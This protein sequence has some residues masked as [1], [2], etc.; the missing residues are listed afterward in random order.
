ML[1]ALRVTASRV[2]WEQTEKQ[3]KLKKKNLLNFI[4]IIVLIYN[5]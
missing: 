2:S 3:Q 5:I 4:D 1:V